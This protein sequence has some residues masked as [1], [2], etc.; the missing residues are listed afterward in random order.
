MEIA[1]TPEQRITLVVG[2]E[3]KKFDVA[4]DSFGN[5]PFFGAFANN[6]KEMDEEIML[7]PDEDAE[8]FQVLLDTLEMKDEKWDTTIQYLPFDQ[9]CLLLCL[10]DKFS[11]ECQLKDASD[12]PVSTFRRHESPPSGHFSGVD[13]ITSF[14][15]CQFSIK[16]YSL[17]KEYDDDDHS[18]ENFMEHITL[19]CLIKLIG[20]YKDFMSAHVIVNYILK[21]ILFHP[22]E[23]DAT[24]FAPFLESLSEKLN[25]YKISLSG[26][27][28]ET[29]TTL[30]RI[31]KLLT[32]TAFR[33]LMPFFSR[34]YYPLG[35]LITFRLWC[36]AQRAV[37][38]EMFFLLFQDI[39]ITCD[40]KSISGI[41][42]DAL[43]DFIVSAKDWTLADAKRFSELIKFPKLFLS[44]LKIGVVSM[45]MISTLICTRRCSAPART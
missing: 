34:I 38:K 25:G 29:G 4:I 27:T 44:S 32:G 39:T 11:M 13:G 24:L 10:M 7:L 19:P 18:C 3:E 5:V 22:S 6:M 35:N 45:L 2:P 26:R 37:P 16:L 36:G 30:G 21:W 41:Q 8:V 31:T 33:N 40:I 1:K 20:T 23:F 14:M 17:P 28:N 12:L 15:V 9:L 42:A 43:I